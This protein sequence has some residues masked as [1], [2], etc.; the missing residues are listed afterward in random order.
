VCFCEPVCLYITYCISVYQ[1]LDLVLSKVLFLE[2]NLLFFILTLLLYS[3]FGKYLQHRI[4]L[5]YNLIPKWINPKTIF[6]T[7]M[8]K[9]VLI[10]FNTSLDLSGTRLGYFYNLSLPPEHTNF[11]YSIL[12]C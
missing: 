9:I 11:F 3:S 7:N 1:Y 6:W 5:C 12:Q 8:G 4:L 10:Y 2:L